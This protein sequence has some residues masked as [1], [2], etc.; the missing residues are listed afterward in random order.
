MAVDPEPASW[1]QVSANL[2]AQVILGIILRLRP[3]GQPADYGQLC[4]PACFGRERACREGFPYRVQDSVATCSYLPDI[5]MTFAIA[6]ELQPAK[7]A[8]GSGGSA[9][10]VDL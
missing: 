9:G 8:R 1:G 3:R 2:H 4:R 5:D 7:T 10:R 6:A